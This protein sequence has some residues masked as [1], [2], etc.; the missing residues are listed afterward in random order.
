MRLEMKLGSF[1]TTV[2]RRMVLFF[3]FLARLGRAELIGMLPRF[4]GRMVTPRVAG[5]DGNQM[6]KQ[7]SGPGPRFSRS[8]EG[9]LP[10]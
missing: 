7:G 1:G 9:V 4:V 8:V 3:F 6:A 10:F 5:V 2:K